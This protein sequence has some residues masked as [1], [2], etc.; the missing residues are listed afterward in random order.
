MEV[1]VLV[2]LQ[3]LNT[4]QKI[5]LSAASAQ[6]SALNIAGY[7][8]N[9]NFPNPPDQYIMMTADVPFWARQV[10]NAGG[11]AVA[12]GTDQYFPANTPIRVQVIHGNRIAAIAAGAGN[13]YLT[14][15]A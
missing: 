8:P 7:T 1:N 11:T 15:G 5:I 14:P 13:L 10:P 12:D 6:S 2:N 3:L 4:S 9:P